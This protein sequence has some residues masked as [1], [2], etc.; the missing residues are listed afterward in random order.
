MSEHSTTKKSGKK[1]AKPENLK[2]SY[3]LKN[4]CRL[5][6]I[7]DYIELICE[8]NSSVLIA[9][10]RPDA[11]ALN[12]AKMGIISEFSELSAEEGSSAIL[13]C[14]RKIYKY[15]AEIVAMTIALKHLDTLFDE[16]VALLQRL[17]VRA[18]PDNMTVFIRRAHAEIKSRNIRRQ[19]EIKLYNSLSSKSDGK[20]LTSQDVFDEMSDIIQALKVN[21]DVGTNLAL[22]ASHRKNYKQYLNSLKR[23]NN[24]K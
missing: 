23:G 1:R 14:L 20:K 15:E 10:G 16:S 11:E 19:S 8:G 24:K 4:K 6:T 12:E 13:D 9:E 7:G 17:G 5:L 21:I 22:Y 2:K 3:T 18:K